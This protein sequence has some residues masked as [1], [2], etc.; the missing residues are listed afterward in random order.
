MSALSILQGHTIIS[1]KSQSLMEV[2]S[3][4]FKGKIWSTVVGTGCQDGHIYID[5]QTSK[6]FGSSDVPTE[7]DVDQSLDALSMSSDYLVMPNADTL[8]EFTPVEDVVGRKL[9]FKEEN[10]GE[11]FW[12]LLTSILASKRYKHGFATAETRSQMAD[13]L[14]LKES[15]FRPLE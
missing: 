5:R 15:S 3:S 2:V 13:W 8:P 1:V 14:S 9:G 11:V 12:F 4:V 7:V 6:S 10:T